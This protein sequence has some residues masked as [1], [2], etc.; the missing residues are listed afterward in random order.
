MSK[1]DLT[2]RMEFLHL[3][4]SKVDTFKDAWAMVATRSIEG[5]T[6]QEEGAANKKGA[7]GAKGR[8]VED[9]APTPPAAAPHMTPV[10]ALL[11]AGTVETQTKVAADVEARA[12][13]SFGLADLARMLAEP[14]GAAYVKAVTFLNDDTDSDRTEEQVAAE[15]KNQACAFLGAGSSCEEFAWISE[16]NKMNFASGSCCQSSS[17]APEPIKTA[18]AELDKEIIKQTCLFILSGATA[19]Q[20]KNHYFIFF[21]ANTRFHF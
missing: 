18:G 14:D 5:D 9:T 12:F 19:A 15:V 6:A 10:R 7:K 2:E 13:N 20:I 4:H 16:A 1:N 11:M 21:C 3:Q 8:S 17:M